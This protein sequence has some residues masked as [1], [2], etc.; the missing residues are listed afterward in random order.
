MKMLIKFIGVK[1]LK[2]FKME[3][4][5]GFK[6]EYKKRHDELWNELKALLK[7]Y[8]IS[9]YRIFLDEQSCALFAFFDIEDE[10][11]LESL[12]KEEIM[13]RWWEFMKDIMLCNEDNSPKTYEL[14]EMFY[15]P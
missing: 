14:K 6:E 15:L 9:N 5:K 2:V 1:M 13:K 7:Q 10:S 8:G 3:L 4:I 12:S 11:K